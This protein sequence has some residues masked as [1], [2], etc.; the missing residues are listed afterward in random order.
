MS[1]DSNHPNTAGVGIS[2]NLGGNDDELKKQQADLQLFKDLVSQGIPQDQAQYM[3]KQSREKG[4]IDT[5]LPNF[6]NLL[7]PGNQPNRPVALPP[8][9]DIPERSTLQNF[10]TPVSKNVGQ[11]IYVDAKTGTEIRREPNNSKSDKVI[12]VGSTSP[13]SATTKKTPAEESALAYMKD[14]YKNFQNGTADPNDPILPSAAKTLGMDISEIPSIDNPTPPLTFIQ[15]VFGITPETPA[16]TPGKT[17]PVFKSGANGNKPTPASQY[18]S[19]EQVRADFQSGKIDRAT[20][21]KILQSQ[22]GH[23]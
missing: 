16:P 1:W 2:F 4:G 23:K 18:Q 12:K 6:Q 22:F 13:A 11:N 3:V 8:V 19:A 21:K 15:K 10:S 9:S 17:Y 20:A 7:Q 14:Y 5:S